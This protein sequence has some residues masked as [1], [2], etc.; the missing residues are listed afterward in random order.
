VVVVVF[1]LWLRKLVPGMLLHAFYVYSLLRVRHKDLRYEVFRFRR[2]ELGKRILSSE[3]LL[4]KVA[5]LLVFKRQVSAEHSIKDDT[6]RP[7]IRL[8][9]VILV[10]SDHLTEIQTFKFQSF[11]SGSMRRHLLRARHSRDFHKLSSESA[12]ACTCC[13][14]RSLQLLTVHQS[15]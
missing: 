5:G 12:P 7:D 8:Q 3:N 11:K 6:A 14:N 1:V 4:I 15:Q 10:A 9:A 13:L 2:K